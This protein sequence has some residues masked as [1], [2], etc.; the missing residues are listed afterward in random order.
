MEA[1]NE[2]DRAPWIQNQADTTR[3]LAFA[4]FSC[5]G[6]L[7]RLEWVT[8]AGPHPKR[9]LVFCASLNTFSLGR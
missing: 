6:D 7:F 9:I 1:W 3:F 2:S 8:N 5:G 4:T